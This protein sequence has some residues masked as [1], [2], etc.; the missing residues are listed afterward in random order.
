MKRPV[1]KLATLVLSLT[2]SLTLIASYAGVASAASGPCNIALKGT[3]P[4][5][6]A[7]A[8]GGRA[9]AQKVMKQMTAAANASGGKFRCEGCHS[10]LDTYALRAN[11]VEDY[12]K[13][14]AASGMK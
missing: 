7:C 6:K 2:L 3:S 10:D 9:E 4:T 12:K 1:A 8:K 5:A 13:L 14:Q 11:A